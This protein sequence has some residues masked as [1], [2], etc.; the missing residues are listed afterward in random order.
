M[1]ILKHFK[2]KLGRYY[3]FLVPYFKV[4]LG[5]SLEGRST[6]YVRNA[7]KRKP[8]N[9]F[10]AHVYSL[11]QFISK[12]RSSTD[13]ELEK[14]EM[15]E[16]LETFP[17]L[18]KQIAL[19]NEKWCMGKIDNHPFDTFLAPERLVRIDG[20]KVAIDRGLFIQNKRL[21]NFPAEPMTIR[22]WVDFLQKN[23]EDKIMDVD[24]GGSGLIH[25]YNC[26]P[27]SESASIEE[28]KKLFSKMHIPYKKDVDAITVSME[29]VSTTGETTIVTSYVYPVVE[30]FSGVLDLDFE[31]AK[32]IYTE[33]DIANMTI[34]SLKQQLM[35]GEVFRRS[36]G[37]V[38]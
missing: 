26:V 21:R 16:L 19:T 13:K 17:L 7:V 20:K 35:P 29:L 23:F 38:E 15:R 2:S 5:I 1:R 36:H 3:K 9:Y 27:L 24:F 28:L 6:E 8:K 34:S 11:P 10:Q 30:I 32:R 31:R 14:D 18:L 37:G 4:R 33:T 25:F 22:Q 12:V